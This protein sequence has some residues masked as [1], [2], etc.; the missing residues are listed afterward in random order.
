MRGVMGTKVTEIAQIQRPGNTIRDSS[1]QIHPSGL[2]LCAPGKPMRGL[3]QEGF[4]GRS[5]WLASQSFENLSI[6]H[7]GH[8]GVA[9][10]GSCHNT[11]ARRQAGKL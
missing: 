7:H 8:N 9:K 10:V 5:Q 3:Q 4:K 2:E 6:F 1:A 11:V